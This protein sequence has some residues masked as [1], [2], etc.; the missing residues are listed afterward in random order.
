M[1]KDKDTIEDKVDS[2]STTVFATVLGVI[3]ICSFAIPTILGSAG[4]GALTEAQQT[5]YGGLIGVIV[6]VLILGLLLPVIKGYNS[7]R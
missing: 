3:L 4:L 1:A 6:I 2:I 5:Q 7:K